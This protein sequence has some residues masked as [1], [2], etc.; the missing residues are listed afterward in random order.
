MFQN[1]NLRLKL[2]KKSSYL[3]SRKIFL[4]LKKRKKNS[5]LNLSQL[6]RKRNSFQNQNLHLLMRNHPT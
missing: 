3:K 5:F 4:R 1:Q 6:L 2:R